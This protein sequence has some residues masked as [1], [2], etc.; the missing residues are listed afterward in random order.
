MSIKSDGGSTSYYSCPLPKEVIERI[1]ETGCI[2]IKD[3]IKYCFYNDADAFNIIKALK[4]VMEA[5]RG[6]GKQGIDEQYDINKIK[7]FTGEL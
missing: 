1:T 6:R 7:F 5:R 2:E 3:V 4:R